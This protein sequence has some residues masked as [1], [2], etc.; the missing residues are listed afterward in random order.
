[1]GFPT[2]I[3]LMVAFIGLIICVIFG[4]FIEKYKNNLSSKQIHYL[5]FLL[6]FILILLIKLSP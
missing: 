3:E 6:S 4:F 2:F 5:F 1:M